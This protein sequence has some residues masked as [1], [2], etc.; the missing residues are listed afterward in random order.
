VDAFDGKT[1]HSID[2]LKAENFEA[3]AGGALL[4]VVSTTQNFNNRVLVFVEAIG[5]P[6]NLSRQTLLGSVAREAR[7]EPAGRRVAFGVFSEEA[8]LTKDF[9]DDPRK[10]SSEVDE[11]ISQAKRIPGSEPALFDSLHQALAT[12]GPH[13]PGDTV[14]LV[15]DFHDH[16]SKH[17]ASDLTKEFMVNG[18]RLVVIFEKGHM[19]R[20][21]DTRRYI[22]DENRALQ[23]LSSRTGRMY[24]DY[25]SAQAL[26]F[27]W[28][29]YMLGVQLPNAWDKPK[30]WQLRLKDPNGKTDKKALVVFPQHLVPCAA[31]VTAVR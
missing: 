13:Q 14:V 21:T 4:P 18:T 9:L 6:E 29:G 1:T 24:S 26:D 16:N 5:G 31:T 17:N 7:K 27:A 28:A 11:V 23:Q 12:F 3:K 2:N 19:R 20:T 10:R 15:T 8:I 25:T 30:E 22:R